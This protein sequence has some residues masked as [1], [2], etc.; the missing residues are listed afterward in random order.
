[1]AERLAD[2]EG[3]AEA[4]DGDAAEAGMRLAGAVRGAAA[5]G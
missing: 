5:A 3:T 2:G 4:G 1:M